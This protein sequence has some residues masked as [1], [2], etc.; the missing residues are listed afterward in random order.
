[1]LLPFGSDAPLYHLPIATVSMI[2][3]N[4]LAYFGVGALE[5]QM[6]EEDYAFLVNQLILQYGTFKP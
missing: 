1:M 4:V 5:G 3:L 2:L 6:S